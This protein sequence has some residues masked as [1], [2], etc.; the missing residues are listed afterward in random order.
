[1]QGHLL[2]ESH[3]GAHQ[4]IELR[5]LGQGGKSVLLQVARCVAIKV[6][7]AAEATPP[8]EDRE[9]DH[10]AGVERRIGPGKPLF[11]RAGVAE[12]VHRDVECGEEGVPKSSM[13]SRF[14]SLRDWVASRL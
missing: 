8:G 11:L 1:M 3:L 2:D 13:R 10:L 6:P 9:G 5:A 4:P 14:L 12:V 7:L